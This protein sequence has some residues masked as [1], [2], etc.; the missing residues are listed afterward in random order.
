MFYKLKR[1][2]KVGLLIQC[3]VLAD[4]YFLNGND[5]HYAMSYSKKSPVNIKYIKN[6]LSNYSSKLSNLID[7]NAKIVVNNFNNINRELQN[8]NFN[9]AN[10]KFDGQNDF[11]SLLNNS[12]VK[13]GLMSS[14]DV[15]QFEHAINGFVKDIKNTDMESL[16][17]NTQK[18]IND[19][20]GKNSKSS[21]TKNILYLIFANMLY[22]SYRKRGYRRRNSMMYNRFLQAYLQRCLPNYQR[23]MPAYANAS[24]YYM[25]VNYNKMQM[26]PY[27]YG[28]NYGNYINYRNNMNYRQNN[29]VSNL[30]SVAS[31]YVKHNS[32]SLGKLYNF[33]R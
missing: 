27:Q 32:N 11:H 26:M 7:T 9:I 2:V 1:L 18:F 10:V 25:P 4:K 8:P 14:S 33:N 16:E 6:D 29:L 28:M 15:F 31:N 5:N 17:T 30:V 24:N 3:F 23:M 22:K 12:V 13:M 21:T 19:N 20:F